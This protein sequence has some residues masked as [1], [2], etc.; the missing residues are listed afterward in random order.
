MDFSE[1]LG[2]FDQSFVVKL[3]KDFFLLLVLVGT[4][5]MGVR[6][7]LTLY[8]FY[9]AERETTRIAAERLASDVRKMMVN[10]GGPVAARTLY[11]IL[12]KN[13]QARGLVI[14]IEPSEVTVTS[15]EDIYDFTPKGIPPDWPEGEHH[16]FTVTIEADE[17]CLSCHTQARVGD[18]LGSVT[19]RSYLSS[20]LDGW[21]QELRLSGIMSLFKIILDTTL[22]F[23]LL[24]VRLEPVLSLRSVVSRLAKGGSDI[25]HRA[26]I[27]SADE[28]GE[29][30]SDLNRFLDRLAL[31]LEDLR[32][33]LGRVAA[34]NHRL[35]EV[36]IQMAAGFKAISDGL[37]TAIQEAFRRKDR[38]PVLSPEW[39]D[40]IKST[41][42]LALHALKGGPAEAGLGQ[43]LEGFFDQLEQAVDMAGRLFERK[44]AAESALL[45]LSGDVRAFSRFMGEMAIL[46]DRMQ[47]IAETG[48]GLVD[49]LIAP[50]GGD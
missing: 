15:I 20:S 28:F 50:E 41:R 27:K 24:R 33:V 32:S 23:F 39:L 40:A 9:G 25:S 10:S 26:P 17:F 12:R 6:F 18:A 35:E 37:A 11:P 1:K 2:R 21:W 8:D 3:I 34:L 46:E 16:A 45:E 38:E 36:H 7:A 5:E 43:D 47:A 49:R 29:L 13:Y 4:I 19:I 31:I 14:A 48:Q 42:G 22:L 30:A 44:D